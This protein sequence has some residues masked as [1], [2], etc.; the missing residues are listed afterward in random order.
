MLNMA[1][2]RI[3]QKREESQNND[4]SSDEDDSDEDNSMQ[5]GNNNSNNKRKIPEPSPG[6]LLHHDMGTGLPFRTVAYSL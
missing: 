2:E 1:N 5:I 3:E 6:D 4:S